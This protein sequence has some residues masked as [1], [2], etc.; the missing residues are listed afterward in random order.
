MDKHLV[1]LLNISTDKWPQILSGAIFKDYGILAIIY[2]N[3]QQS[4]FQKKKRNIETFCHG[5]FLTWNGER[6]KGF[7]T[8]NSSCTLLIEREMK[9]IEG[10]G[11]ESWVTYMDQS[12]GNWKNDRLEHQWIQSDLYLLANPNWPQSTRICA[13]SDLVLAAHFPSAEAQSLSEHMNNQVGTVSEASARDYKWGSFYLPQ[14][15]ILRSNKKKILT[16]LVGVIHNNRL[17]IESAL[18]TYDAQGVQSG[19]IHFCDPNP[20]DEE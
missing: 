8:W 6:I 1:L 7:P 2:F 18:C 9:K 15:M 17:P 11:K 13:A 5:L 19:I 14:N 10:N 20:L 12:K 3:N 4:S 16:S